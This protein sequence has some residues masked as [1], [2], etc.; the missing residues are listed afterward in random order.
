[1][2]DRQA[3]AADAFGQPVAQALQLGDALVDP[4]LPRAR[5]PRPVAAGRNALGRQPGERRAD[6]IEAEADTLGEDDE[7]DAPQHRT[8]IAAMA[9][10]GAFGG[11]QPALLVKA[12]GRSG[13]AA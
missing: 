11:D 4:L 1:A 2:V 8:G 6:L 12:Q 9:G 3:A 13:D 5:E 7:G 10:A